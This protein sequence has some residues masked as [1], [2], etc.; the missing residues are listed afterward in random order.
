MLFFAGKALKYVSW[1]CSA[2]FLYHFYLIRK[3]EKPEEG[4]MANDFFLTTALIFDN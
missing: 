3:R 4:F 1:F 2:T